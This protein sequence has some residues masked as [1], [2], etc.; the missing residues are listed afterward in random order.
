MSVP[1]PPRD[2]RSA[3]TGPSIMPS[4]AHSPGESRASCGDPPPASIFDVADRAGVS[5]STVSRSLRGL[6][7]VAAAT[8]A[9]VARAAEDLAYVASPAAS[10]LASGRTTTVGIVVPFLTRWFF[11]HVVQG[12]EQVLRSA[13]YDVLLH[14]LEDTAGRERFFERLPLNRK[15]D[16]IVLVN[17][18]LQPNEQA[19]LQAVGVPVTVVGG[20]AVGVG[21]VGID[22]EAGVRMAIQHLVHLGHRE[23][24]M[25]CGDAADGLG[26]AVPD[27]RRT[28]FL[29]A[30][31]EAGLETSPD[32][33][34]TAEWG[35]DG[36]SAAAERLLS[37]R[38]MPT[39]IFA[40]CDELAFGAL[41]TFRL[42]GIEVPRPMSVIG[43]DNHE[44]ASV[45]NLTTV[46]QPVNE[47][48][49]AAATL[50]LDAMHGHVD[51]FAR[52]VMPTR[53]VIRGST[54]PPRRRRRAA[55]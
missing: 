15:V 48:G 18:A 19:R 49:A 6:P 23:I 1:D 9:R 27:H 22:D 42:A 20:N 52:I 30:I 50:L 41:R 31:D 39:A 29:R 14:N 7:N 24:G 28:A 2:T 4:A 54:G 5:A 25:V 43:F 44:M 53:L 21:A 26:F 12:I 3:Q 32:W 13:K 11:M 46:A 34:V 10:G 38:R 37:T 40:E 8:R 45:V 55:R 35:I 33:L 47:Q 51:P 16:G 17:L 36:G